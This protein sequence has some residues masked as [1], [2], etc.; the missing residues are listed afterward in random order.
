MHL[1]SILASAKAAAAVLLKVDS[2]LALSTADSDVWP[3]NG[4]AVVLTSL[5]GRPFRLRRRDLDQTPDDEDY[6]ESIEIRTLIAALRWRGSSRDAPPPASS[7]HGGAARVP[8][9]PEPGPLCPLFDDD[10]LLEPIRW[11]GC[12]R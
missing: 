5:L 6:L 8:P 7:G 12:S 9:F 1:V 4:L 11:S 10:V 2:I 3:E